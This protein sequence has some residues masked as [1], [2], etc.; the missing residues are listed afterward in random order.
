MY[1]P[2]RDAP[3]DCAA[4]EFTDEPL[5]SLSEYFGDR[6]KISPQYFLAGI[7]GAVDCCLLRSSAVILLEDALRRLPKGLTFKVFDAWRPV[8]VQT[9]LFRQFYDTLKK[10]NPSWDENRLTSETKKFVSLPSLNPDRPS[11]HNSGGAI[12]LTIVEISGGNELDMG[13][14]FDDF[15]EKSLTSHFEDSGNAKIRDNRR[16]LYRV[17]TEAGFTN[18]PL[19][20]WHYDYGDSFW[21]YYTGKPSIYRGI[22]TG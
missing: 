3:Q 17:M 12:D 8:E 10:D 20:W 7:P 14:R 5:I 16:L 21:S 19:E 15:T 4:Y 6:I 11:V 18:Y 2:K 9:A 13:T 22:I 1:I